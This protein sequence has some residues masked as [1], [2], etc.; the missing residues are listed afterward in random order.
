MAKIV[1]TEEQLKLINGTNERLLNSL[2]EEYLHEFMKK[3]PDEGKSLIK[4]VGEQFGIDLSFMFTYGAGITALVGPTSELIAGEFPNLNEV[5]IVALTIAAVGVIV[6]GNKEGIKK[7]VKTLK[8]EGLGKALS[9][10]L[11]FVSSFESLAENV[12]GTAGMSV[13]GLS[14]IMGFAFIV[15]VISTLSEIMLNMGGSIDQ[16]EDIVTRML[17]YLATITVGETFASVLEKLKSKF[18]GKNLQE[19]DPKKGTG[20]KPKGSGRRLYTDEN[21]KDTVSVKFRTKQDIVDTLNKSSFKSKSH[22]RQSQIINLIHQRVRA[23][24]KNAKDPETKK[25]LKKGLDYITNKKEKSKLKTI[26]KNKLE[27]QF[28]REHMIGNTGKTNRRFPDELFEKFKKMFNKIKLTKPG[29]WGRTSRVYLLWISPMGKVARIEMS[30][31]ASSNDIPFEEFG[32]YTLKEFH[33]F[34]ES[35]NMKIEVEGKFR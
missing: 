29:G 27:E 21:P 15:P 34:A 2:H 7:L 14:K 28:L 6:F 8:E 10:V 30:P 25:R 11:S 3:D 22:K 12:L 26:A 35:E 9:K 23:A 33:D 4:R 16:V 31:S 17:A 24:H 32:E 13:R 1:I 19:S 20:K 5:Q 18:S